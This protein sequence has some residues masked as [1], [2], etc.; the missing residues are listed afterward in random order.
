MKKILLIIFICFIHLFPQTVTNNKGKTPS[1]LNLSDTLNPKLERYGNPFIDPSIGAADEKDSGAVL[2]KSDRTVQRFSNIKLAVESA[3][4][5]CTIMVYPGTYSDSLTIST[6][7]IS[8]IGISPKSVTISGAIYITASRGIIESCRI[9]GN[10]TFLGQ[11][12]KALFYVKDCFLENNINIGTPVTP[13]ISNC[14]FINCLLGTDVSWTPKTIYVNVNASG[15]GAPDIFFHQC[16]SPVWSNSHNFYLTGGYA[17]VHIEG[18]TKIA[19]N[20]ITIVGGADVTH[21][22]MLF[23]R[24]CNLA[25]I[26]LTLTGFTEICCLNSEVT[27]FNNT[28]ISNS[29]EFDMFD[30]KIN[31]AQSLDISFNSTLP[32]RWTHCTGTTNIAHILGSHLEKLHIQYSFFQQTTAPVGLGSDDAN[33]W[34]VWVDF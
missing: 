19:F 21:T 3:D 20:S 29:C 24:G 12:I 6:E 8:I 32:S 18:S 5:N 7:N 16:F 33:T 15:G 27:F 13:I 30:C 34:G 10:Q 17:Q 22:P 25:V 28:I 1:K 23:F 26:S 9:T 31:G 2:I 14:Y 11:T 4:P